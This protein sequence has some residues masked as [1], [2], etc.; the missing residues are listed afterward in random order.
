MF[1]RP[2]QQNWYLW[3]VGYFVSIVIHVIMCVPFSVQGIEIADMEAE[4]TTQTTTMGDEADSL[5]SNLDVFLVSLIV[6]FGIY[7]F[8]SRK[9]PDPIPEFKKLETP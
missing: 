1:L 3:S 2:F 5:F 4:T 9:K 7:W 8:M 6:G